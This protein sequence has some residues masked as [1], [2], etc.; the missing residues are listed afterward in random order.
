M[1]TLMLYTQPVITQTSVPCYFIHTASSRMH[2]LSHY[3]KQ[4]FSLDPLSLTFPATVLFPFK[5]F[6]KLFYCMMQKYH[7]CLF[8]HCI[9]VLHH[10]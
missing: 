3:M 7:R 10:F 5:A 4:V 1:L 6:S 2:F 9:T 8:I